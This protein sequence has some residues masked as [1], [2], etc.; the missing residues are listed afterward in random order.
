MAE[1][2]FHDV[3][4][5]LSIGKSGSTQAG[6]IRSAEEFWGLYNA[7]S[8]P[9]Q[10]SDPRV[11]LFKEHIAPDHDC[12]S[13]KH[14]CCLTVSVASG[15]DTGIFESLSLYLVSNSS[16]YSDFMCGAMLFCSGKQIT[17]QLWMSTRHETIRSHAM[18]EFQKVI[19]RGK[20]GPSTDPAPDIFVE[21]QKM[22]YEPLLVDCHGKE[23]TALDLEDLS[24]NGK[25]KNVTKKKKKR[26]KSD[27]VA[28]TNH[29]KV[30]DLAF[31]AGLRTIIDSPGAS[32]VKSGSELKVVQQKNGKSSPGN[33]KQR[34]TAQRSKMKRSMTVPNMSRADRSQKVHSSRAQEEDGL[35]I[36]QRRHSYILARPSKAN[37]SDIYENSDMDSDILKALFDGHQGY[38]IF[39]LDKERLTRRMWRAIHAD[40]CFQC[41]R[42]DQHLPLMTSEQQGVETGPYVVLRCITLRCFHLAHLRCVLQA[43]SHGP[44]TPRLGR[45][46]FTTFLMS[47]LACRP[48]PVLKHEPLLDAHLFSLELVLT[49]FVSNVQVLRLNMPT[50]TRP[51]LDPKTKVA[52][53]LWLTSAGDT[54]PKPIGMERLNASPSIAGRQADWAAHA[55]D[56]FLYAK[57]GGALERKDS[58]ESDPVQLGAAAERNP[59]DAPLPQQGKQAFGGESYAKDGSDKQEHV[60][61]RSATLSGTADEFEPLVP[62]LM[63]EPATKSW[64]VTRGRLRLRCT[65]RQT[66]QVWEHNVNFDLSPLVRKNADVEALEEESSDN[67]ASSVQ[68]TQPLVLRL[69]HLDPVTKHGFT[70]E[71]ESRGGRFSVVS[72][73]YQIPNLLDK[74]PYSQYKPLAMPRA[75]DSLPQQP[76]VKKQSVNDVST[77]SVTVFAIPNRIPL[78]P[79]EFS[80]RYS[81]SP[82]TAESSFLDVGTLPQTVY[83]KPHSPS[84]LDS[85]KHF[86]PTL[87]THFPMSTYASVT[88]STFSSSALQHT[89][90]KVLFERGA[91]MGMLPSPTTFGEGSR[92]DSSSDEME[93]YLPPNE[94]GAYPTG[95]SGTRLGQDNRLGQDRMDNRLGQDRLGQDNRLSQDRLGQDRLDKRLGQDSRLGED[96]DAQEQAYPAAPSP[97][98]VSDKL[99]TRNNHDD[100]DVDDNDDFMHGSKSSVRSEDRT[101]TEEDNAVDHKYL[102]NAVFSQKQSDY[103]PSPSEMG[104]QSSK[105]SSSLSRPM[106]SS[107]SSAS[108]STVASFPSA[109]SVSNSR[110]QPLGFNSAYYDQADRHRDRDKSDSSSQSFPSNPFPRGS[111]KSPVVSS[112]EEQPLRASFPPPALGAAG[113]GLPSGLRGTESAEQ[114]RGHVVALAT[115]HSGSRFVQQK[116]DSGDREF[117]EVFFQ[118][119][120]LH[121][122]ELM[123]DNFGHFAVEKLIALCGP[124]KN[125]EL[126]ERVA[127]DAAHVV[128]HRH[129]SFCIQA[130]IG[131]IFV[132]SRGAA[133]YEAIVQ[134]QIDTL[135]LAL[136]SRFLRIVTNASGHFVVMRML[137]KFSAASMKRLD[138]TIASHCLH[139]TI[140]YY[141]ILILYYAILYYTTLYYTI[142]YYTILY[143]TILYYTFL[144]YTKLY[145]TILYYTILYYTILYYTILYY[146]ILY[147]SKLYYTILYYTILYYTIL[148]YTILYY[149]ILYFSKLYYTILDYTILYFSKLYYTILYFSKLYY[150]ILYYTILYYTI[151]YCT[152]LHETRYPIPDTLVQGIGYRVSCLVYRVSCIVYRYQYQYQYHYDTRYTRHETR[153]P[154]PDTLYPVPCVL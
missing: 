92:G 134:K 121:I 136:E 27:K 117:F 110:Q 52:Y 19:Q 71:I 105:S 95:Q 138:E 30:Y 10:I 89:P 38:N 153:Y 91:A 151:L 152:V 35:K 62:A 144:N 31:L 104:M 33:Q 37:K 57:G 60:F 34:A 108:A 122:A 51:L 21:A 137:Q 93:P 147:F 17:V 69:M 28:V 61:L 103:S 54:R 44:A 114:V 8:Y 53:L 36:P 29:Y 135:V 46:H 68:P 87:N 39:V 99:P 143:Y 5:L 106:A 13:N 75:P 146:T 47:A 142:L 18:R 26:R 56:T 115:A 154:I 98:A 55:A 49:H 118:E 15:Q 25:K 107:P 50:P 120:K 141:T 1:T 145:Y 94:E 3:W 23:I 20:A 74:A 85:D 77:E 78:G 140:Q 130:L 113:T 139:K 4:K 6:L 12:D 88:M 65:N 100:H 9:R 66:T 119:M 58:L 67:A 96:P 76:P 116:L 64:A 132:S 86:S 32:D 41:L 81:V 148:Y 111:S 97:R 14:G 22:D 101:S 149:T 16:L 124:E 112:L 7:L 11:G 63:H 126:V 109:A 129:G 123:V 90:S 72:V 43:L 73:R 45:Y 48:A 40:G 80:Y 102:D 24:N 84:Q 150:T 83:P 70:L 79:N 59:E 128:C 131:N 127:P 42:Q 125:L 2:V 82:H 133:Q